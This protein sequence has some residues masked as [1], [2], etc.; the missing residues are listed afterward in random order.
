VHI[1][2]DLSR[3]N[4]QVNLLAL[5]RKDYQQEENRMLPRTS[6]ALAAALVA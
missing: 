4:S 1:A 5:P 6:V 3:N 2:T